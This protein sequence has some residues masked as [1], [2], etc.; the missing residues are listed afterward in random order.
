M[1]FIIAIGLF[2]VLLLQPM[3]QLSTKIGRIVTDSP[4]Q[5]SGLVVGET[6]THIDGKATPTWESV[7]F[8]LVDRM[9]EQGEVVVAT[10]KGQTAVAI[11][12]FMQGAD[13]GKDPLTALGVLP[14][15]PTIP[16][17]IGTLTDDG[18]G[19][20][21]GLKVGDTITHIDGRAI[22]NWLSVTDIIYDS[23][24]KTLTV[25]V[26][27]EGQPLEL[28]ITP[29]AVKHEGRL[30]GRI[31]AG[32]KQVSYT[33][34]DEYKMVVNHTPIEALQKA[35]VKTYDLSM[36]TVKSMGK[37]ITGL[38]GLDNLSGPITIAEV[39]KDSIE[40][41]WLQVLFTAGIISLSLAVLNLMPIPMLDG[42]HLV[43]YTYELVAGRAMN[44]QLQIKAM[45]V[46]M[47]LLLGFMMLAI[48][49]DL[50]RIF[51]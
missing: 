20:Q 1:N 11:D 22:D 7:N 27:R 17:V 43:F 47:M 31:G 5:V 51:G 49:N 18:A 29:K 26:L 19:R 30:I 28:S 3:E 13:K 40:R 16:P 4:A 39:S 42:G 12:D 14:Y 33:I 36:M 35:F 8:A 48:G 46:G 34:P 15:S 9:G 21:A 6:I 44:E 38:I 24:D 10:D 37:M 23:P 25:G 50:L 45:Q 2:F 41:G 32:V